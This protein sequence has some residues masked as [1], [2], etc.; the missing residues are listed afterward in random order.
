M[1][2]GP[3]HAN[4]TDFPWTAVIRLSQERK[5]TNENSIICGGTIIGYRWIL[6]SATCVTKDRYTN[7]KISVGLNDLR[8]EDKSYFKMGYQVCHP[9]AHG[10]SKVIYDI[11]LIRINGLMSPSS[12][13]A[14]AELALKEEHMFSAINVSSYGLMHENDVM[15]YKLKAMSLFI[16]PESWCKYAFKHFND[17]HHLCAGSSTGLAKV[18]QGDVGAGFVSF[19]PHNFKPVVLGVISPTKPY[20]S[21]HKH[22]CSSVALAVKVS[23]HTEWIKSTIAVLGGDCSSDLSCPRIDDDI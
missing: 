5:V 12:T 15:N 17:K 4:I 20:Q 3:T 22:R 19:R 18:C 14:H 23:S 10:L 9:E 7:M 1:A 8:P 2:Y 16:Q 6:T 11:C 21:S 13:V